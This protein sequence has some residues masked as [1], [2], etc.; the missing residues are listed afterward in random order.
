LWPA[1]CEHLLGFVAA[2]AVGWSIRLVD[3]ALDLELDL[4]VGRSNLCQQ[5][6]GGTAAYAV[7]AFAI[8][9]VARPTVALALFAAAYLMGMFD[10]GRLLPTGL[11]GWLEGLLLFGL[12]LFRVGTRVAVASL[13][14]MLAAQLTDDLRDQ[15]LDQGCKRGRLIHLL[16]P[17]GVA[18][19]VTTACAFALHLHTWLVVYSLPVFAYFQRRERKGRLP[20]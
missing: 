10:D 11:P 13:L 5:L 9:V 20:C 18:L 19:V 6:Q 4:A 16:G 12:V 14:V 1:V 2:L 15:Q 7:A 3:D 17:I 8:G